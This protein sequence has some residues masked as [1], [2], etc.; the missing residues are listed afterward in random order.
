MKSKIIILIEIL[1]AYIR[2]LKI[3]ILDKKKVQLQQ[4]I[5]NVNLSAS[6]ENISLNFKPEDNLSEN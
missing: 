6:N 4:V 2:N 1:F 5:I 3:N